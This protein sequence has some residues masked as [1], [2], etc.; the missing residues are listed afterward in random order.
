MQHLF[1]SFLVRRIIDLD[2][3]NKEGRASSPEC[4]SLEGTNIGSPF[5][6]CF[7]IHSKTTSIFSIPL[8][9]SMPCSLY[10]NLIYLPKP[11]LVLV[12]FGDPGEEEEHGVEGAYHGGVQLAHL[13]AVQGQRG[14]CSQVR[15]DVL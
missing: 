1:V 8:E 12:L 4:K 13:T 7:F 6:S 15:D 14:A 3:D 10:R 2:F 11:Y 5:Y 9:F